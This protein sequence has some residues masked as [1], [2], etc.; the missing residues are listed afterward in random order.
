MHSSVGVQSKIQCIFKTEAVAN[1]PSKRAHISQ[2]QP[3]AAAADLQSSSSSTPPSSS[4]AILATQSLSATILKLLQ[5]NINLIA[6]EK[7][8]GTCC[9]V[10]NGQLWKRYDRKLNKD[11]EK[12]RNNFKSNYKTMKLNFQSNK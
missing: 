11:G 5:E 7:F 6:T 12:K 1:R 2:Q 10:K 4:P 9:Q 8:D 3:A